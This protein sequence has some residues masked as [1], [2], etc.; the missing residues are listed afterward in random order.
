VVLYP[1]ISRFYQLVFPK[2]LVSAYYVSSLRSGTLLRR[3][4]AR[5]AGA[6]KMKNQKVRVKSSSPF[7]AGRTGYIQNDVPDGGQDIVVISTEPEVDD[8]RFKRSEISYFAV[9]CEYI[10]LIFQ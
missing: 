7:H 6:I 4:Y 2:F 1:S 9:H 10:E 3:A 5:I 8:T